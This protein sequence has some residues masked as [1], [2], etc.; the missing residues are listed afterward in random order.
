MIADKILPLDP[1]FWIHSDPGRSNPAFWTL[2]QIHNRD[3]QHI[4]HVLLSFITTHR[5]IYCEG[6]LPLDPLFWILMVHD[7]ATYTPLFGHCLQMFYTWGLQQFLCILKF[8]Y[9]IPTS[10]WMMMDVPIILSVL[11]TFCDPARSDPAVCISC[12]AVLQR[13][14]THLMHILLHHDTDT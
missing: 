9:T 8:L 10:S 7:P 1:V 11:D 4:S 12:L 3:R 2:C 14:P 6:I 13:A 5:P